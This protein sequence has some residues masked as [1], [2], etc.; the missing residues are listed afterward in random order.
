M[1]LYLF[2]LFA[3]LFCMKT[4]ASDTKKDTPKHPQLD[5]KKGEK[6]PEHD[7]G[8]DHNHNPPPREDIKRN[9]RNLAAVALPVPTMLP[10][11]N[12]STCPGLSQVDITALMTTTNDGIN[13]YNA[14][15]SEQL[16]AW[17]KAGTSLCN[18]GDKNCYYFDSNLIQNQA[19]T[20]GV[21]KNRIYRLIQ[22]ITSSIVYNDPNQASSLQNYTNAILY[23]LLQSPYP[24]VPNGNYNVQQI[25]T[26]LS[27]PF[28]GIRQ[29]GLVSLYLQFSSTLNNLLQ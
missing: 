5:D 29:M 6:H 13:T 4:V 10:T 22:S 24:T 26:F 12:P 15:T 2:A 3:F 16:V 18:V 20:L 28:T 8:H 11:M 7:R 23:L 1:R 21:S 27:A 19:S 25:S 17:C 14:L 9:L